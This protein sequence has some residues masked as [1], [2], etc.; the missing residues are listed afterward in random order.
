VKKEM[1]QE[2][3]RIVKKERNR[4]VEKERNRIVEKGKERSRGERKQS[5]C[6]KVSGGYLQGW[7][8][9]SEM[10]GENV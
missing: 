5:S 1:S 9:M 8:Q 2:R 4:I 10:E 7:G 3:N 6:N